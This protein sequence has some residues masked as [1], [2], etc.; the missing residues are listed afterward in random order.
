MTTESER[1]RNAAILSL[2]IGVV[3]LIVKVWA[4]RM[5]RSQAVFS[6]AMESIVNV[7]AAGFAIF[8]V[9]FAAK[10]ADKDHPY[11]HGKIE[12]FSAAFEGGLITFAALMICFEALR[13]MVNGRELHE[14]NIGVAVV[15]GAGVVNL[16]LGLYLLRSGKR[17]RSPALVAS[18]HH[19]ISDFWTSAGV[20][21]GLGLVWLTGIMWLDPLIAFIAGVLLART[22]VRLARG[23]VSGLLDEEDREILN[24]LLNIVSKVL[25]PGII[26]IHHCRVIRSGN[27]HHIDAHVVVPEF[28]DVLKAHNETE[29][30]ERKVIDSYPNEGELHFHVDPCRR[31]YCRVCEVEQCPVR[32]HPFETRRQW[33]IDEMTNPTE[34][35]QFRR[36]K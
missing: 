2:V 32:Q 29:S 23:S 34:P 35:K 15:M 33:T 26:Q 11:G 36:S 30:F 3:L 19:V 9:I 6:D 10:P 13:A 12:F 28:W 17:A 4:Y 20:A 8:V 14:L 24:T 16:L 5:T 31:A 22:G 25:R 21:I 27:Y 18:G 7:I 1:S